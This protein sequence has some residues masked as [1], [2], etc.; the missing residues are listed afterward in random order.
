[1]GEALKMEGKFKFDGDAGMEGASEVG[2]QIY[3]I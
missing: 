3:F 2:F 1:M